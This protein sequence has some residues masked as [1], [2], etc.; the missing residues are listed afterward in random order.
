M[1]LSLAALS[2][3]AALAVSVLTARVCAGLDTDC[4]GSSGPHCHQGLYCGAGNDP[5][6]DAIDQFMA[7]LIQNVENA[8]DR[9]D[10]CET[11]QG[12]E[13]QCHG[14]FDGPVTVIPDPILPGCYDI[15]GCL[16]LECDACTG[17]EPL[18]I[19]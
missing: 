16:P 6:R 11:S 4:G 10:D 1:K 17:H 7:D 5:L 3:P 18:P 15:S 9:C 12:F 19:F 8:G 13:Y 14:E 2:F